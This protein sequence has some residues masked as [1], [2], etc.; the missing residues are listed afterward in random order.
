MNI[1]ESHCFRYLMCYQCVSGF[2]RA[3]CEWDFQHFVGLSSYHVPPALAVVLGQLRNVAEENGADDV[4]FT[5]DCNIVQNATFQEGVSLVNS[6]FNPQA[7]STHPPGTQDGV[8]SRATVTELISH[9]P[10]ELLQVLPTFYLGRIEKR[11]RA[12]RR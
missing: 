7:E 2:M 4:I 6:T 11:T 12:K 10:D 8:A 9:E 3:I 1:V 5:G